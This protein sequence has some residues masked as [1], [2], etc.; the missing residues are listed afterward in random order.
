MKNIGIALEL[1]EN[2]D[3][4]EK[5]IVKSEKEVAPGSKTCGTT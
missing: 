4:R 1:L 5:F 2:V 3:G